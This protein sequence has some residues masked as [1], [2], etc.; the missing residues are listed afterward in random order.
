[1]IKEDL[2]L[3]WWVVWKGSVTVVLKSS[4]SLG[5][6]SCPHQPVHQR[7][8]INRTDMQ[9]F[10]AI[11][12]QGTFVT[13]VT[14]NLHPFKELLNTWFLDQRMDVKNSFSSCLFIPDCD[15]LIWIMN[16]IS[17]Y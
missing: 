16:Q 1:M 9:S 6:G 7:L 15:A 10:M 2:W 3:D 4:N 5:C 13:A 17:I 8:S 14:P 11:V 12:Q